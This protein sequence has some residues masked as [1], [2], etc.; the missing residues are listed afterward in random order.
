MVEAANRTPGKG[1]VWAWTSAFVVA[2]L[3]MAAFV[4][5]GAVRPDLGYLL[6]FLPMALLVPMVRAA[7]RSRAAKGCASPAA[8]RYNRRFVVAAFAYMIALG[9]AVYLHTHFRLPVVVTF[10]LSL[11]PTLAIFGMIWVMARYLQEET[12]EYM[13][14]RAITAALGAMA[15]VLGLGTFWGFLE[16]FEL[17]PHMPGWFTVP[18][19][20]I[21]LALSQL[22]M[23]VRGQ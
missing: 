12:D 10:V 7:E 14:H 2:M 5:S 6:M 1:S 9:I 3:G 19:F 4:R 20:A 23:K 16:T 13:R 17:V 22:W 8:Q 21:G 11:L 15:L 18:V